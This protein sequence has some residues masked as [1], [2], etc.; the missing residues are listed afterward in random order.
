MITVIPLHFDLTLFAIVCFAV[1]MFA[2]AAGLF[3]S[4]YRE[5][6]PQHV[7]MVCVAIASAMKM[8]QLFERGRVSPETALL[9]LGVAL[10][11]SGVAIKVWQHRRGWNGAERRTH[12]RRRHLPQ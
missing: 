12:E 10:F 4:E 7:G 5:N 3:S 11:A 9:A 2:C 1:S 6:W 8:F